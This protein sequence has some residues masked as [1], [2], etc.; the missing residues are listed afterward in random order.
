MLEMVGFP[1]VMANAFKD[2]KAHAFKITKSNDEDEVGYG[3]H[4][5]LIS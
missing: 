5:Y 4:R 1:I 2:V 3:I